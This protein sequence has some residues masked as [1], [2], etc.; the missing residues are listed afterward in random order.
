M[1]DGSQMVLSDLL[2][3]SLTGEMPQMMREGEGMSTSEG[4]TF[5]SSSTLKK[6]EIP[7]TFSLPDNNPD[8]SQQHQLLSLPPNI[9]DP[10]RGVPRQLSD[11]YP[12][13]DALFHKISEQ[14]INNNNNN[15]K[16]TFISGGVP[17]T[18][19]RPSPLLKLVSDK[20]SPQYQPFLAPPVIK[21]VIAPP[22]FLTTC[23]PSSKPP[24]N[25]KVP[26]PI[27]Y[28]EW[29]E[30]VLPNIPTRPFVPKL[31]PPSAVA[32]PLLKLEDPLSKMRANGFKLLTLPSDVPNMQHVHVR[33]SRSRVTPTSRQK[34]QIRFKSPD[35]T[36]TT[37]TKA[38]PIRIT[39]SSDEILSSPDSSLSN[40]PRPSSPNNEQLALPKEISPQTLP[41][42]KPRPQDTRL[43]K[44]QLTLSAIKHVNIS[45]SSYSEEE[46]KEEKLL[47]SSHTHSPSHHSPTSPCSGTP[48]R[49]PSPCSGTPPRPPSP[50]SPS[51]PRS[52]SHRSPSLSPPPT[53][54]VPSLKT[55]VAVQVDINDKSHL[56]NDGQRLYTDVIDIEEEEDVEEEVFMV[57]DRVTRTPPIPRHHYGNRPD[58]VMKQFELLEKQL[59]L[60][61]ANA[62][63]IKDDFMTS[64]RILSTIDRL[65]PTGGQ[66][67][68]TPSKY[69]QPFPSPFAT[70]RYDIGSI[71]R[72]L[73]P[74]PNYKK[75]TDTPRSQLHTF[76]STT[77]NTDITNDG[78]SLDGDSNEK[79]SNL[80]RWMSKKFYERNT[81]YKNQ[82]E[83]LRRK[84]KR[85]FKT[86]SSS[87]TPKKPLHQKREQEEINR[88]SRLKEAHSLM[89]DM[90]QSSSLLSNSLKHQLPTEPE[91]SNKKKK[92]TITSTTTSIKEKR[93]KEN[94]RGFGARTSRSVQQSPVR[95]EG[96]G[97]SKRRIASVE[98]LTPREQ[99]KMAEILA[100]FKNKRGDSSSSSVDWDEVDEIMA[101]SS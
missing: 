85:P 58:D 15:L 55:S 70:P 28:K 21:S 92:K 12:G 71:E 63:D 93:E 9:N 89:E 4:F 61:E 18:D 76:R 49:S 99:D 40:K 75:G 88:H 22:T 35:H 95:T 37:A 84:E 78:V 48:P 23:I 42:N 44:N 53:K 86:K 69:G 25:A 96:G 62:E 2:S 46:E 38:M 73:P 56:P 52:P 17:K 3:S 34:R 82:R 64:R 30:L 100:T 54:R 81:E 97:Y 36:V 43:T 68:L 101:A 94:R 14:R 65:T 87:S 91:T 50:R 19:E 20:N 5:S 77:P 74:T 83:E 27:N 59:S 41:S 1:A 66:E 7:Q 90:L 29:V 72:S 79:R 57:T 10:S 8:P 51:P 67:A 80:R 16:N 47:V 11:L 6:G 13:V 33:K 39:S 45:T 32:P 98:G 60:L 26:R 24:N 31:L